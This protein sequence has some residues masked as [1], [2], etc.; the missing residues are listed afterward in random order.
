VSNGV[1]VVGQTNAALTLP[2]FRVANEAAYSVVISNAYGSVTSAPA[3]LTASRDYG[4]AP[5]GPY[6]TYKGS[7]GARRIAAPGSYLGM[8]LDG[9]VVGQPSVGAS[10]E[11]DDDGVV[12]TSPLS[13]GQVATF[14]VTA[15]TNG[16]LNAWMDF[17]QNGSWADADEQILTNEPL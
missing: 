17:N 7:N 14:Q 8:T 2:S 6:A 16:Y 10:T 3:M 1:P 5:D 4:D 15:S 13:S 11:A 9:E 12:L